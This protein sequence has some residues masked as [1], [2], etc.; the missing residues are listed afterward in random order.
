VGASTPRG[1]GEGWEGVGGVGGG[2]GVRGSPPK[3]K[4]VEIEKTRFS[5]IVDFQ[6]KIEKVEKVKM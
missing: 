2:E 6:K 4:I 5:K 1:A 3:S